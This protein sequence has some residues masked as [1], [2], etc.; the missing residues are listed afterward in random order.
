MG[1]VVAARHLE[2]GGLFAIKFL[3]PSTLGLPEAIERFLREA[4]AAAR[5]RGEH[6]ARVHDVGRMENGAPYMVLEYL[7]GCDLKEI[8]KKQGPLSV[9]ETVTY[10]LQVCDAIAEAHAAG[11]VHRDLKPANLFLTQ[12]PNGSPC[13]KVLD[14]GISK[15]SGPEEVDLTGTGAMFGSPLYMSPEQISKTKSVDARTDIWAMGVILYELLTGITPFKA[16]TMLEVVSGV[17]Q[18]EPAPPRQRRP[19]LL[20]AVEAVILR[21]LR[22]K[23]EERF[24]SVAELMAALRAAVGWPAEAPLG[25]GSMPSASGWT[26][27]GAAAVSPAE[28]ATTPLPRAAVVATVPLPPRPLPIA[29]TPSTTT[30]GEGTTAAWGRTGKPS[31]SRP[32]SRWPV[33]AGAALGIVGIA[34]AAWR[35]VGTSPVTAEQPAPATQAIMDVPASSEPVV[36][37]P[38]LPPPAV[39]KAAEEPTASPAPSAEPATKPATEKVTPTRKAV[40]P[41]PPAAPTTTTKAA[42]AEVKPRTETAPAPTATTKKARNGLF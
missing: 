18:E 36:P 16:A 17:L 21:C 34:V 27:M 38:V 5:L 20:P 8:V 41:T 4:R 37:A 40:P 32:R 9:E 7:D 35:L 10:L 29:E 1:V 14:F 24:Q 33:A 30:A 11:I 23:R 2:L 25:R 39:D 42:A 28:E 15:V 12:R 19:D 22:K 31:P 26:A 6:V 13:V 3:L